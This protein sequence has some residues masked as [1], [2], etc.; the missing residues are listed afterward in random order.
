MKQGS[1]RK[2]ALAWMLTLVMALAIVPFMPAAVALAADD[3]PAAQAAA[4][5][6]RDAINDAIGDLV[7]GGYVAYDTTAASFQT[8]ILTEIAAL[9]TAHPYVEVGFDLY[10]DITDG[11]LS[12]DITVTIDYTEI[13]GAAN[14]DTVSVEITVGPFDLAAAPIPPRTWNVTLG[15]AS[16]GVLVAATGSTVPGQTVV[17]AFEPQDGYVIAEMGVIDGID[18]Y[19]ISL[20]DRTITFTMPAGTGTLELVVFANFVEFVAYPIVLAAGGGVARDHASNNVNRPDLINDNVRVYAI[21]RTDAWI[22]LSTETVQLPTGFTAVQ[23]SINGGTRWQNGAL[24]APRNGVLAFLNR[25][26]TLVLRNQN[27]R[28]D[29]SPTAN[30]PAG[31]VEIR[32]PEIAARPRAN[33]ASTTGRLGLWYA[34]DTWTITARPTGANN[35]ATPPTALAGTALVHY[36]NLEWVRGDLERGRIPAHDARVWRSLP[37]DEGFNIVE[38]NA[39]RAQ[40]LRVALFVRLAP[41]VNTSGA[42]NVYTPASR[43]FRL[44]P[45]FFRNAT[46]VRINYVTEMI[47]VRVG[48]EWSLDGDTFTAVTTRGTL[49]GTIAGPGASPAV[50]NVVAAQISLAEAGATATA[51]HTGGAIYLRAATTGRRTRTV[52]QVIQPRARLAISP[53]R[54][55][56]V[57]GTNGRLVAADVRPYQ[58]L[59]NDRWVNVPVNPAATVTSLPVRMRPTARFARNEWTGYAAGLGTI[60]FNREAGTLVSATIRPADYTPAPTLT[61]NPTSVNVT[62]AT[63]INVAVGGNVTGTTTLLTAV[64]TAFEDYVTVTVAAPYNQIV[65]TGTVPATGYVVGTFTIDVER[66]GLT[67]TLTVNLSLGDVPDPVVTAITNPAPI[68]ISFE[69]AYDATTAADWGLPTTVALVTNPA[70]A[71]TVNVTW[72]LATLAFD[73]NA[74]VAQSLT[75]NAAVSAADLPATVEP[76]TFTFPHIVTAAIEVAA[77]VT[78]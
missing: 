27:L 64:P 1:F 78:P 48:Q 22:C 45:A 32:F 12:G 41:S 50:P 33:H 59:V 51:A 46:R 15:P 60:T 31:F 58:A 20:R 42:A 23:R 29:A 9:L 62:N 17:I 54:A 70:G 71:F 57:A 44:S 37:G 30:I 3:V 16:G 7:V 65:V 19:T 68:A 28:Q 61:L 11:E 74:T 10:L 18:T 73:D 76:G 5:A 69:D 56:V 25:G 4:N 63:A 34:D 35:P 43:T 2:R 52:T 49:G 47:P 40:R 38:Q 66:G 24:P 77:P 72:D 8:A 53:T 13:T 36:N 55:N 67:E 14:T 39:D 21:G 75:V 26:G 6:V